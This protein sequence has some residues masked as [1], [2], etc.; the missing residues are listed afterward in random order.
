[1]KLAV[2]SIQRTLYEG[3]AEKVIAETLLGQMAVLDHHVPL[4]SAIEGP[5]IH[6]VERDGAHKRIPVSGGVM[7]IRPGSEVVVLAEEQK[8]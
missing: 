8:K 6:I 3:E 5:H 1:M 7:E 4:I 2:Y